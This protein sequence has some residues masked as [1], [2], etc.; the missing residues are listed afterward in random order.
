MRY[1]LF[2]TLLCISLFGETIRI[3]SAANMSYAVNALIQ[4]Y[5][6]HYPDATITVTI[7]SSGKLASQILHGAPYSIFLSA[8]TTY[9]KKLYIAKKSSKPVIYAQGSLVLLSVQEQNFSNIAKLL[10]SKKI[11]KIAI[12]NPHTAPY[13]KAAQQYLKHA[14][15]YSKVRF[16]FVYG[17][18]IAQTLTYTLKVTDVGIVAKSALF[19]PHMHHFKEGK[20]WVELPSTHYAP[21]KQS[22]VLIDQNNPEAQRFFAFMQSDEAHAILTSYGYLV[23]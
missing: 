11:K 5:T 10:T 19:A 2:V 17:E 1:F 3:A 23:P 21:I 20:N 13:G 16:K 9:P 12:A 8:N 7:A 6:K 15:L 4:T 22:M 18:S 14:H